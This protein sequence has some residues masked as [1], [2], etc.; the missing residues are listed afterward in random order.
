[1]DSTLNWMTLHETHSVFEL[2]SDTTEWLCNAKPD[3][4]HSLQKV[5]CEEKI[6]KRC[7]AAWN[8]NKRKNL[9]I[10]ERLKQMALQSTH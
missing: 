7:Y 6:F 8:K 10:V 5:L 4:H 3:D 2:Q 1:L 9:Y